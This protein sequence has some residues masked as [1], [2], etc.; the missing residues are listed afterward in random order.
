MYSRA[1]CSRNVIDLL[2]FE[3]VYAAASRDWPT[4]PGGDAD[5]GD[6]DDEEDDEENAEAEQRHVLRRKRQEVVVVRSLSH[7]HCSVRHARR[8]YTL[9]SRLV[10]ARPIGSR[11]R[12]GGSHGSLPL[13]QLMCIISAMYLV[14]KLSLSRPRHDVS[15]SHIDLLCFVRG[16]LGT[17]THQF[18]TY[19]TQVD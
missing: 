10:S 7:R 18:V 8:L 19:S 17:P 5:D 1:S 15:R 3:R 14:N 2:C 16:Y 12:L 4:Y 13:W 9:L 6:D 11:L